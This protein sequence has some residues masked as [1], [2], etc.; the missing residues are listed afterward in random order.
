MS[1]LTKKGMLAYNFMAGDYNYKKRWSDLSLTTENY[2]FFNHHTMHGR[3]LKILVALIRIW[4]A[5]RT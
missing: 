1:F 4:R 3:V 5:K 2:E